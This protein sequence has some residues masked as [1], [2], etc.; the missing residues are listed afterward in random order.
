M[1]AGTNGQ[2]VDPSLAPQLASLVYLETKGKFNINGGTQWAGTV[3]SSQFKAPSSDELYVH[4][5]AARVP[6]HRQRVGGIAAGDSQ[7]HPRLLEGRVREARA[8]NR[9]FCRPRSRE[10]NGEALRSGRRQE[11]ARAHRR[12]QRLHRRAAH[13]RSRPD[14]PDLQQSARQCR[15]VH[16]AR[17]RP[18]AG[19]PRA[20]SGGPQR[21]ARAGDRHRH[22]HSSGEACRYLRG[23]Q[24]GGRIDDAPVWRN[25]PR[26]LHLGAAGPDDGRP[27][28][29]GE[30]GWRRQDVSR[31]RRDRHRARDASGPRPSR[32]GRRCPC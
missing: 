2:F 20:V 30:H 13:R 17:P 23:V 19:R 24:P 26:P 11:R 9:A 27:D 28:L 25:G 3:F 1:G 8:R 12:D 14:S 18:P 29:V 5:R 32:S 16:R 31:H 6:G 10:A 15:E 7:R 21:A 22:R 4:D